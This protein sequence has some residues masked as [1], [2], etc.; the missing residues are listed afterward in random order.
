MSVAEIGRLLLVIL[1]LVVLLISGLLI[2]LL[3]KSLIALI[4]AIALLR[5][6]CHLAYQKRGS[7]SRQESDDQFHWWNLISNKLRIVLASR[8][9]NR[10][11]GLG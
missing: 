6:S 11:I 7:Q 2:A 5:R 3:L 10:R 8:D 1:L 4:V 9:V